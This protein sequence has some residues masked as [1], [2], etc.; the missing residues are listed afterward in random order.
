MVSKCNTINTTAIIT[1]LFFPDIGAN[2]SAEEQEETL[3]EGTKQVIDVVDAFRLVPMGA[4]G[5]QA[6]GTKKAFS[7]QFKG[8]TNRSRSIPLQTNTPARCHVG[9]LKKLNE[10]FQ[11]LDPKDGGKDA[12]GIK[13]FQ[14]KVSTYFK[15]VISPNFKDYDFYAGES[16]DPDGMYALSILTCLERFALSVWKHRWG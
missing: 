6:F 13:E 15:D 1:L 14:A 5:A 7:S 9:Y 4:D 12:D 3:E 11:E 16:M 8:N 10:K 2:P